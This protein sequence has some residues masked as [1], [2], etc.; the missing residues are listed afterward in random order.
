VQQSLV[1][2]FRLET[3]KK[4]KP[5]VRA[6]DEFELLRTLWGSAEVIMEHERLRVQEAL[7]LVLAGI[8]GNRPEA[9]LSLRWKHVKMALLRDP[10]GSEWP[11]PI[12]D[13]TFEKTKS[14]MGAKDAYVE[15]ECERSTRC[16]LTRV[17][18]IRSASPKFPVNPAFSSALTCCS[19]A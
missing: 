2:E 1:E 15:V 8:T 5:I 19:S 7:I 10:D 11:R 12:V 14:Y 18:G 6:E 17:P 16:M 9:L 3:G 4:P 13:L